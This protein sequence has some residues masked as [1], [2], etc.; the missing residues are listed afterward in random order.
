MSTQLRGR[1]PRFV[2]ECA[3]I[4]ALLR[5][6]SP[7]RCPP[8]SPVR[9]PSVRLRRFHLRRSVWF[10]NGTEP[11]GKQRNRIFQHAGCPGGRPRDTARQAVGDKGPAAARRRRTAA[12]IDAQLTGQMTQR[13]TAQ[14]G[15]HCR[16][17][18]WGCRD[19][20]RASAVICPAA[21]VCGP[22]SC[23]TG[24]GAAEFCCPGECGTG[25]C[26]TEVHAVYQG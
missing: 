15:R 22:P 17:V 1:I 12:L 16:E 5:G 4:S 20:S 3:A 11:P 26:R 13:V 18:Q 9:S 8:L 21:A 23:R 6:L 7:G 14:R 10:E 24:V 19:R 25:E 2:P